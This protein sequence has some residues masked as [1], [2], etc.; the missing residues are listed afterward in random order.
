MIVLIG[1]DICADAIL[2]LNA[3][4][5]EGVVRDV[6]E[7]ENPKRSPPFRSPVMIP[8]EHFRAR[9]ST[10]RDIARC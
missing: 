5:V 2:A 7:V 4:I 9:F 8:V 6:A 1:N 3:R 10:R